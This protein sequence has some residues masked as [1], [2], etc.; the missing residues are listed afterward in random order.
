MR[1]SLQ[2]YRLKPHNYDN[3]S[4]EPRRHSR[5]CCRRRVVQIDA[6]STKHPETVSITLTRTILARPYDLW[7]LERNVEEFEEVDLSTPR[8]V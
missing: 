1:C 3:V 6:R 7:T 2:G 5:W 8:S 4:D